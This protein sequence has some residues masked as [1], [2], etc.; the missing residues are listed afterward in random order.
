MS[1]SEII[2][3][4]M[5]LTVIKRALARNALAHA[6][7]FSGDEGIGKRTTALA[8]AAAVNCR[9][10]GPEGG[11]GECSACRKAAAHTH[12]DIHFLQADGAE[13]KIDQVRQAQ[14]DLALKPFEGLKKVLIVD[15]ADALNQ[16]AANAFLK[17]LEEP[18]GEA[19]IIL[20]TSRPASLLPTIRSRCQEVTFRPF[21]R[22]MLAG[23]LEQQRGLALDDALLAA[24]LAGGSLGRGLS[25]DVDAERKVRDE[26]IRFWWSLE[27]MSSTEVLAAAE[28]LG[29]DRERF[30]SLLQVGEEWLRDALVYQATADDRLLVSMEHRDMLTKWCERF[31]LPRMLEDM[32]R[33]TASRAMLDRRANVQLVAEDLFFSMAAAA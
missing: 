31:S 22:R 29:K 3:H 19:L 33:I 8:L 1:F 10:P 2:G 13:I 12:P 25:M 27:A 18:P 17:T 16:A 11:C 7:L 15:G 30:E 5:P 24:S 26:S 21:S 32:R 4:E 14:A 28:K 9:K 23:V 6:Y 20:V